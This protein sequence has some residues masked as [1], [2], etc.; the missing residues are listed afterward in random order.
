MFSWYG[1]QIFFQPSVAF[2]VVPIITIIITH[3]LYHIRCISLHKLLYSISFLL[4]FARHSSLP[5]QSHLTA[6]ALWRF[7]CYMR[8]TDQSICH[9]I[10]VCVLLDS[11]TLL[12]FHTDSWLLCVCVCVFVCACVCVRANLC[13]FIE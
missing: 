9:N 3:P 4:P 6:C 1:F 2:P 12:I 7:N 8:P 13:N 5:V 10:S 11:I